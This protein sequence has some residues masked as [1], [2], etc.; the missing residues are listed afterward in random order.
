MMSTIERQRDVAPPPRRPRPI[1]EASARR[2]TDARDSRRLPPGFLFDRVPLDAPRSMPFPHRD[3]IEAIL[4]M[5]LAG[6]AVLDPTATRSRGVTALADR[7]VARFATADPGPEV[8][9]HEATHLAQHA[10]LITDAGLGA[11]RHAAAIAS[12]VV[13]TG[14]LDGLLSSRGASVPAGQRAYTSFGKGEG[15]WN[16]A[17]RFRVSDD[18][19][20][21]VGQDGAMHDFWATAA[22]ISGSNGTLTARKSVIRLTRSAT[23]SRGR[24]PMAPGRRRCPR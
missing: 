22:L 24:R 11:E 8:A 6:A 4:G 7:D 2:D 12:A 17:V 18:G 19:Q 14:R 23:R 1:F 10:G 20:M 9:A 15:G 3:Q 5:P 16:T 21:A 13:G